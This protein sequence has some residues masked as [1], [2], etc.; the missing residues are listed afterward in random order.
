MRASKRWRSSWP[1]TPSSTSRRHGPTS[2][3]GPLPSRSSRVAS[4]GSAVHAASAE[5]I[6]HGSEVVEAPIVPSRSTRSPRTSAATSPTATSAS[7]HTRYGTHSQ[8]QV[9]STPT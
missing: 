8:L 9:R 4:T 2:A 1:L 6:A 5:Q 7:A 3:I